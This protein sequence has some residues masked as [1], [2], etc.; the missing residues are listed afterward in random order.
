MNWFLLV[1]SGCVELVFTFC[2][3]KVSKTL[4]FGRVLEEFSKI[5]RHPFKEI[6]IIYD[7]P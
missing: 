2:L 4:L 7:T 3:N 6:I 1:K 5:Q